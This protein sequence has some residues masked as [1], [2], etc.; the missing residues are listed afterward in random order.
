MFSGTAEKLVVLLFSLFLIGTG[1]YLIVQNEYVCEGSIS[2]N[3]DL[4]FRSTGFV[5]I[6]VGVVM[7]AILGYYIRAGFEGG[8]ANGF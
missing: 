4:K 6:G 8:G 5:F 1:V 7:G 3:R 2:Q